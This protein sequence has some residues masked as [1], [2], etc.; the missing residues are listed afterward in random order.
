MRELSARSG[1][2][3]SALSDWETGKKL[4]R[5]PELEATLQALGA[6]AS[7]RR[8]CLTL[9][10]APRAVRRLWEEVHTVDTSLAPVSGGLLRAMRLRR[11]LRLEEVAGQI[12]V[13]ASTI[14]RWERGDVWPTT[15]HLHSLCHILHAHPQELLALT[16]DKFTS[17]EESAL[18][19]TG[20]LNEDL[21]DLVFCSHSP[22]Q[23]AL[24]DL[25]FLTLMHRYWTEASCRQS[26]SG[27]L[28]NSY[29]RYGQFLVERGRF[30]EAQTYIDAVFDQI[31]ETPPKGT[32][33]LC[34]GNM[35]ARIAVYSHSRPRPKQGIQILRDWLG[36]LV[37]LPHANAANQA[38]ALSD[39]A[40]YVALDGDM[41]RSMELSRE[42]L[43]IARTD[44]TDG[45][46]TRHRL[47]DLAQVFLHAG[48]AEEALQVLPPGNQRTAPVVVL[49]EAITEV[50]IYLAL[51]K[52]EAAQASL[53]KADSVIEPYSLPHYR[54][55][56]DALRLKVSEPR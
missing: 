9:L 36:Y 37:A 3:K 39:L 16:R 15:E 7:K 1:V 30:R 54:R 44:D 32:T 49:R 45:I 56:V 18:D 43:R 31:K 46:D 48:H 14:S 10:E 21:N 17:V 40:E 5:L 27:W 52:R 6:S 51:G 12:G 38:W 34:A 42:A 24:K 28:I 29:A 20:D 47:V 26:G 41:E 4:P 25:R 35:A 22:H 50:K 19:R 33:W 55:R 53:H 11:D 2:S 8:Q 13:Q 23:E